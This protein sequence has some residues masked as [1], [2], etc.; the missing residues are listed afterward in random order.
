MLR[1]MPMSD[2]GD[3]PEQW[4]F[5]EIVEKACARVSGAARRPE[6]ATRRRACRRRAVI[7]RT[8]GPP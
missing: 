7:A 4:D 5:L 6:M 3:E 1:Y 2:G 8:R